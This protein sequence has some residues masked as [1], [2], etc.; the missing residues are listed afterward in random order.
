M[1]ASDTTVAVTVVPMLAP[2]TIGTALDRGNGFSGAATRATIIDVVTDE[3]WTRVVAKRP[4]TRPTK[5]FSVA[6]KNDW[7]TS[8]P[9]SLNPSPRPL[10]PR[11]K[12]KRRPKAVRRRGARVTL[13]VPGGGTEVDNSTPTLTSWRFCNRADRPVGTG[14][15]R[16]GDGH[17]NSYPRR[18]L[19]VHGPHGVTLCPATGRQYQTDRGERPKKSHNLSRG[20]AR[21]L[22]RLRE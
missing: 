11:R 9:R 17:S 3:L 12:T 1:W 4:T 15:D 2:M 6:V 14:P 22:L 5:G 18:C 16:P 13:V 10:T 7:M 21:L 19:T 20:S 8:S